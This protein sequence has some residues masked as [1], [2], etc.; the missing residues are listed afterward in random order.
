MDNK[1]II[2]N[3]LGK[4]WY[5]S[6]KKPLLCDLDQ[7]GTGHLVEVTKVYDDN[8]VEV[9]PTAD[10]VQRV[11]SRLNETLA[12]RSLYLQ[13]MDFVDDAQYPKIKGYLRLAGRSG[14]KY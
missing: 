13:S 10:D 9:N 5:D 14:K 2:A 8:G 4:V 1:N 6:T 7:V 11:M 3:L 12:S